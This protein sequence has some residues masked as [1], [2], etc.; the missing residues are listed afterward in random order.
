M[1]P[2]PSSHRRAKIKALLYSAALDDI[3]FQ[4]RA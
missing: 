2:K 1:V 4:R 3:D